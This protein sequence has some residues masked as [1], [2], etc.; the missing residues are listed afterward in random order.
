LFREIDLG[1]KHST[2]LK[3]SGVASRNFERLI[4]IYGVGFTKMLSALISL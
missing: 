1:M 3:I 2:S 4:S